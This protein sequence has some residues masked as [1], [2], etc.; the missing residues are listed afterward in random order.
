V[1]SDDAFYAL[2]GWAPGSGLTYD[3]VPGP[4]TEW[5]LAGGA[6]LRPE[7]P[8]TLRWD[9]GK[10]LVFTRQIAVDDK[11]MFTVTDSV[12]N[13]GAAP[14]SLQPY[15]LIRRHGMPKD[16]RTSSS[17]TKAWSAAPMAN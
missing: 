2:Q 17:S 15:G 13:T 8:V 9:N 10:G 1:G 16:C 7:E 11:F 12:Q 4:N 3:D 6:T 5:K 14:V